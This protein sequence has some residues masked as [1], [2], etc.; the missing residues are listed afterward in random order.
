MKTYSL[1]AVAL[2]MGGVP[3]TGAGK[4]DFVTVTPIGDTFI[5]EEGQDGGA[6]RTYTGS[7]TA[8][9]QL[10]LIQTSPFNDFLSALYN[11][12]V[13]SSDVGQG[14]AGVVP[15]LLRDT[16]GTTVVKAESAFVC[17]PPVIGRKKETTDVVWMIKGAEVRW[18]VGGQ[19][20]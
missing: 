4:D 6:V 13:D 11:A 15:F 19:A 14:G 18:E 2:I 8:D 5:L 17:K 20:A 10:T 3:A 7:K 9:I 12:D 16:N 1:S